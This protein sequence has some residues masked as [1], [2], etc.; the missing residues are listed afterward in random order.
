MASILKVD[1]LQSDTG[2]INL[3]SNLSLA[4][5][6]TFSGNLASP[7]IT[8]TTNLVGG[9][10][11][12]PAVQVPSSD[13]NTLDDYEEGSWTPVYSGT[14]TNPTVTYSSYQNGWYVKIGKL[15]YVGAQLGASA[16]SGGSGLLY[17]SGL[18]FVPSSDGST[19]QA[20]SIGTIY[21]FSHSGSFCQYGCRIEPTILGLALWEMGA[22]GAS[23]SDAQ[24][25]VSAM[26]TGSSFLTIA[27]MYITA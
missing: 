25:P 19:W 2:T 1:Q 5:G 22:V 6:S 17:L 13:A 10:I 11:K 9:Q 12:F 3:A 21:G 16:R 23:S 20:G 4:T 14:T 24:L 18:P 26:G 27:A 15:V 8:G 7:I